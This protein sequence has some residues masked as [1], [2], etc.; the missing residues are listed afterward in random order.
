[1]FLLKDFARTES[2]KITKSSKAQ[3]R[4]Q[5]KAQNTTSEQKWKMRLKNI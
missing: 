5:A 4:N 3:R 1:M 2:T